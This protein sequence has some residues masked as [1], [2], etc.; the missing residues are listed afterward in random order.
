MIT[1]RMLLNRMTPAA[2]I[3]T[4][5][6]MQQVEDD[7][8]DYYVRLALVDQLVALIGE[9]GAAAELEAAGLEIER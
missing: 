3:A 5:Q 1:A 9:D 8:D 7:Q 4:L 2:I 6:D